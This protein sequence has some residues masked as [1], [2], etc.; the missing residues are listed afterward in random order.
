M[1]NIATYMKTMYRTAIALVL[2]LAVSSCK[3]DDKPAVGGVSVDQTEVEFM[4]CGG[5]VELNIATDQVWSAEAESDWCV[6]TP[7]TGVGDGVCLLKADSS[8]LYKARQGKV[9]FYSDRGDIAEILVKQFGYEPVIEVSEEVTIPS[10]A[11]PEEAHIDIEA[12]SNV[13]FEVVVPDDVKGWL[14]LDESTPA[15]YVPSTTIPR[16]QKFR[17]NF[18]TYT[19]FKADRFAEIE[20]RQMKVAGKAAT[21]ADEATAEMI[22]K[23]VKIVQEA[24]PVIIP[25]REGDSLAVL[26]I[27]RVLGVNSLFTPSRPITHWNNILVEE[28]TYDYKNEL[29]G[30]EKKDS[31]ELRVVGLS[32]S[33]ISVNESLPYQIQY[34]TELETCA[35]TSNTNTFL[36]KIELGP[37]IAAL[38]KLRSLSLMGYGISK[39]PIE[40]GTMESLEELD[41]GANNILDLNDIK[42]VLLGLKGQLKYLNLGANR[43]SGSVSNLKT[44]IP[45]GKTLE[46]IG[47]GGEL[48]KYEWFFREMKELEYLSLS[49]NYFYGSVPAFG[50]NKEGIL[51]KVR[52]FSINLNRLTGKL[53]D[54]ILYHKNLA[55]WNPFI[56]VFNQEGNDPDGKLAGFDNAP[57]KTDDFPGDNKVCPDYEEVQAFAAKLPPLTETDLDIVPLH[58]Y[59]RYYTMFNKEW[60]LKCNRQQ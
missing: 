19:D 11:A 32:L 9:V 3:D 8:Y 21:R 23:K 55:C 5:T 2:L 4:D 20:F 31:T 45:S 51:P 15:T 28:R 22:V 29:T 46:T 13:E 52:T 48:S 17:F 14:E 49:Y 6:V 56:L 27:A 37:E 35:V 59:W 12:T 34:L 60:Y 42:D 39:L 54:W 16:K 44:D 7:A 58:G 50:G 53:P 24:A 57:S 38:K 26:S 10:Y 1:M 43:V 18:K 36:K 47:L 41:L 33:M 25:S 40:M 30:Y